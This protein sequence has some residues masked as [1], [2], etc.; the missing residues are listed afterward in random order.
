M[1]SIFS[2]SDQLGAF[3]I[4]L[5]ILG[6]GAMIALAIYQALRGVDLEDE[7]DRDG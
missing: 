1:L 4:P 6:S 3:T 7:E 2:L 5:A